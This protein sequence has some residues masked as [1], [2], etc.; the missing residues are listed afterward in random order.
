ME[1]VFS[2]YAAAEKLYM[3]LVSPLCKKHG[4]TY[5][6]FTVLMF[7]SNNPQ[8]DT[9]ADIVKYRHLTKSHVSL[10]IRGLEEKGLLAGGY[11]K[12]NRKSVHLTVLPAAGGVVEDGR[13]AQRALF[14]LLFDGFSDEERKALLS[15]LDRIDKNI[16]NHIG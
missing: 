1:N 7:L 5:M 11:H 10:S 6:E 3:S 15:F 2:H 8:F 16:E 4:L 9:A 14:S 13:G 12:P